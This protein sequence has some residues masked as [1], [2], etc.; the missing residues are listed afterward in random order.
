[1]IDRIPKWVQKTGAIT[2]LFA[3]AILIGWVLSNYNPF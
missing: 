2:V 1:M 3:L